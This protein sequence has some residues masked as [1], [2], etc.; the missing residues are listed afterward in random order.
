M[1]EAAIR[2][3]GWLFIYTSLTFQAWTNKGK[4]RC[5]VTA[6]LQVQGR[7]KRAVHNWKDL[8]QDV[9]ISTFVIGL[10]NNQAHKRNLLFASITVGAEPDFHTLHQGSFPEELH[11]QWAAC[12]KSLP[13]SFSVQCISKQYFAKKLQH[14]LSL[15]IFKGNATLLMTQAPLHSGPGGLMSSMTY[16]GVKMVL[17]IREQKISRQP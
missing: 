13:F 14:A 10:C 11:R 6:V 8:T 1:C 4:M 12:R 9:W 5:I 17:C 15:E 2:S 7:Q 16:H 3:W